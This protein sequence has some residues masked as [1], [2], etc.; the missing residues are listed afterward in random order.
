MPWPKPWLISLAKLG[1]LLLVGWAGFSYTG[2]NQPLVRAGTTVLLASIVAGSALG[3]HDGEK[4]KVATHT[5]LVVQMWARPVLRHPAYGSL[6]KVILDELDRLDEAHA[7]VL[8]ALFR[9]DEWH[10]LFFGPPGTGDTIV[11]S[12]KHKVMHSDED[13]IYERLWQEVLKGRP[14]AEDEPYLVFERAEEDRYGYVYR[15]HLDWRLSEGKGAQG[16]KPE[17]LC[18]F[19]LILLAENVP[20]AVC[21][22]ACQDFGLRRVRNESDHYEDDF[23]E[24]QLTW[25][26][27]RP[28]DVY[29]NDLFKFKVLHHWGGA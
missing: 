2:P 18:K 27:G 11:W 29:E 22:K 19:P 28:Y 14:E 3:Q 26:E 4:H 16:R 20:P 6:G 24:Y 23:G 13:L 10:F 25:S 9:S 7:D 5:E 21:E 1:A 17:V 8:E 12:A 15:M